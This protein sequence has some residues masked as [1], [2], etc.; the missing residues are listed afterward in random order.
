[1]EIN[2]VMGAGGA[3]IPSVIVSRLNVKSGRKKSTGKRKRAGDDEDDMDD[4][5]S[6]SKREVVERIK[7]SIDADLSARKR[8][9]SLF[10]SVPPLPSSSVRPSIASS[11]SSSS[12]STPSFTL[13]ETKEAFGVMGSTIEFCFA[14]N[15]SLPKILGERRNIQLAVCDPPYGQNVGSWDRVGWKEVDFHQAMLTA[16]AC[17]RAPAFTM[18]FFLHPVQFS[19]LD[20]AVRT[21]R[22]T[23]SSSFVKID[24]SH[25]LWLKDLGR[26]I[27][28]PNIPSGFEL[29]GIVFFGGLDRVQK[30]FP[31]TSRNLV[32]TEPAVP[33]RMLAIDG[34]TI[35]NPAEK[36]TALARKLIDTFSEPGTVVLSMCGGLAFVSTAAIGSGR[37]VVEAEMDL[38]QFSYGRNRLVEVA[39]SVS[40]ATRARIALEQEATTIPSLSWTPT[41][42]EAV[43]VSLG[44]YNLTLTVTCTG[45][46]VRPP[47]LSRCR[48]R[49]H[50]AC[51]C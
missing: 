11:S 3:Q 45:C 15:S 23:H 30:H 37:S 29:L 34:K 10:A 33:K 49:R 22:Q 13:G 28:G 36:P 18:V 19:A 25:G 46:C 38:D 47:A 16:I 1:M 27:S 8:G 41:Q 7:T 43:R 31:P 44:Y 12:S 39:S 40:E 17:T 50:G 5:A 24:L 4:V 51:V 2:P 32:F 14:E 6:P 26:S 48:Q 21:L 20:A 35:V 9:G 42:R